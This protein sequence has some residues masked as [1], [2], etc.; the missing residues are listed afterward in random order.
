MVIKAIPSGYFWTVVFVVPIIS[1]MI[2]LAASVLT[3]KE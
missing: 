1:G 3:L 2:A